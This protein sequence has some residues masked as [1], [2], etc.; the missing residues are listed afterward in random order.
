MRLHG[1]D[2]WHSVIPEGSSTW[3]RNFV[4]SVTFRDSSVHLYFEVR[5]LATIFSFFSLFLKAPLVRVGSPYE[6]CICTGSLLVKL[7]SVAAGVNVC[8]LILNINRT[9]GRKRLN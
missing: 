2:R 9:C 8:K 1:E 7:K 4:R 6:L 3:G 5:T